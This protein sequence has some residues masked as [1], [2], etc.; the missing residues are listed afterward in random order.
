MHRMKN[1]GIVVLTVIGLFALS[2]VASAATAESDDTVGNYY[3]DADNDFLLFN[4]TSDE[5]FES[6]EELQDDCTLEGEHDYSYHGSEIVLTPSVE[7][8][9]SGP[10]GDF[11]Y[12]P[13]GQINHGTIMKLINLLYEGPQRGCIISQFAQ[14]DL[15][16]TDQQP[17]QPDFEAPDASEEPI[18]S[19]GFT[20]ENFT[21]NCHHGPDGDEV[22]P[23]DENGNGNGNGGKPDW[24]PGPPPWAATPGGPN[25]G[26]Q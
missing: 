26:S 23:E 4:V 15:G 11:A 3:Y 20:F 22:E 13:A 7:D 8:G 25:G 12:G 1:K 16:K 6:F 9:C 21:T 10:T 5:G 14:T 19:E 2:G 18:D 17:A 24:A